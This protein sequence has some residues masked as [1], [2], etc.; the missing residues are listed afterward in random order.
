MKSEQQIIKE[1]K[2]HL[3]NPFVISTGGLG[4]LVYN[5]IDDINEFIPDLSIRG[6]YTLYTLNK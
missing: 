4:Q 5:E 1:L 3:D 2:K 6:L